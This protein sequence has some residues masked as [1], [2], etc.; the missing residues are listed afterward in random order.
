VIYSDRSGGVTQPR[1]GKVMPPKVMGRPAPVI[2]PGKDRREALAEAVTAQDNPFFAK[3]VANRVWYHL[4]GRGIVDPV[5]DFRDSNPSAN[6]ALLDA[7]AKDFA[8]HHFDV[9]H[10]IRTVMN[11]R[12]YQLSA[13]ANQFNKDDVKYFS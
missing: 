3:S 6:D 10:L 4:T 13:Q 2:P 7:L 9:K 11:S 1:S 8:A 5:D 12:T